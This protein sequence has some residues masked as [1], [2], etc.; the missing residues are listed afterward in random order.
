MLKKQRLLSIAV[1]L[2]P[3]SAIGWGFD[4]HKQ[5]NRYAVYTLPAPLYYYVKPH[6]KWIEAHAPDPD[7]KRYAVAEEGARHYIDIEY[8]GCVDSIP[9]REE[10]AINK[11]TADSLKSWGHVPWHVQRL[12]YALV[13]AFKSHDHTRILK[14]LAE[15]G[16]YLADAHVPLHTTAN[17]N[18]QFSGQ[19]GIHALLETRS[20]V[21]MVSERDFLLGSATYVSNIRRLVW[22]AVI[23]SNRALDTVFYAEEQAKKRIPESQW[24]SLEMRKG[25][26][27]KQYSEALTLEFNRLLGDLVRRR[28]RQATLAV[29]NFWYSAWVDAGQPPLDLPE[30]EQEST[31]DS[32]PVQSPGSAVLPNRIEPVD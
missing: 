9:Q 13:Q 10:D 19:R 16:H 30:P 6:I 21:L 3:F 26:L 31:P 20:P 23:E 1:I 32:M 29:G 4:A 17:Y 25:K 12:Y 5:I 7:A 28:M 8:Y 27:E 24:Y 18:G 14:L 11:F 15:T 2:L 22:N